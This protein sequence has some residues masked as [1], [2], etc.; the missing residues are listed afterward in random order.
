V[1]ASC[2]EVLGKIVTGQLR[3]YPTAKAEI[4]ELANERIIRE[5]SIC[6]RIEP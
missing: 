1:L 2:P 6:S 4:P 3:S 5:R